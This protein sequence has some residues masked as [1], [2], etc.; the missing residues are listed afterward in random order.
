[1]HELSNIGSY[2]CTMVRIVFLHP[3]LGIGGAERAIIDA[4]LAIA[5]HGHTVRI[6]TGHHDVNHCFEETRDGRL[7]V[8]T[9]GDWLPRSLLGRCHALCAYIRMIY[10]AMYMVFFSR[11][12]YD[13]AFCDQI[14]ACIP[15]LRLKRK[16]K[17]LFYCHFPDMLLTDR[18]S[19]LKRLY[20]APIDWL[21]EKTTG[22]ADV[23][24]VNSNFTGGVFKKTFKSLKNVNPVVVYPV[25]NFTSFGNSEEVLIE[26]VL[27]PDAKTTFLSINRY[28]RKKNLSLAIEA[29]A[30]LKECRNISTGVYLIIAGGYDERVD[31]NRQYYEELI[32][33]ADRYQ[34]SDS[35]IFLRSITTQMKTMLM[36][37]ST[38]LLY[39]PDKEHFGIVPVE[40]M[41]LQCPVIAINSGGPTETVVDGVTGFLCIPDAKAFSATMALFI[42]SP[43]LTKQLGKSGHQHVKTH[44]S[45][46]AYSDKLNNIILGIHNS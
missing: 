26:N 19:L 37:H 27:P 42:D 4:A 12:D 5:S 39:T 11:I 13:L 2:L 15:V 3:D 29:F 8:T 24:L 21:E 35:V 40:A 6:V 44:F 28:E 32:S 43:E 9:I 23:I 33:L 14:S 1:M 41:Y 30:Y 10:L 34:L 45:F 36:K 16:T 18:K 31:E 46:S 20:R 7:R 17:I 25:P 22:M 38:C